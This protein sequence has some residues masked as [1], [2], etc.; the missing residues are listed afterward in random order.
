MSGDRAA[1]PYAGARAALLTQHGKESVVTP[2]LRDALSVDVVVVRDFDTDTL[3][4][5]T[6]DIPR[7]GSQLD[8]A[9]KKAQLA[10]QRSGRPLGLGSE[11][12]FGA[13]PVGFGSWNLELVVL[14]DVVRQ[15]EIV[16]RAHAP[17]LHCHATVGSLDELREVAQRARFPEHGLVLRPDAHDD[18]RLR[19]GLRSWPDLESAFCAAQRESVHGRVF[20]ENDLRAHQHPSRMALIASAMRDLVERL[21]CLCP[22]CRLPG[23]GCVTV[24]PGLPCRGCG[25]ATDLPLADEYRCVACEKQECRRRKD[26]DYAEP[27]HCAL[28][29][30]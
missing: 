21:L 25:S 15:I 16:G 26:L 30:P 19:K 17:G 28:C 6:R 14:V 8:A 24:V 27:F 23:F 22:A 2:A 13:G 7:L 3:G 20:V 29:N 18:V 10:S 12:S 11:G 5:F 9:R 1:H 4:T